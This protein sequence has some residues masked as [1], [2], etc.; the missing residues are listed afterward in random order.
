M[1][2]PSTRRSPKEPTKEEIAAHNLTHTPYRSW[3]PECV[4]ARGRANPHF[5]QDKEEKGVPGIHIDYLFMRDK[6]GADLI[7]VITIKDDDTKSVRAHVVPRKG[8]IDW[9]ADEVI[10][11]ISKLGHSAEVIIKSDQEPALIDLRKTIVQRRGKSAKT[12]EENAKNKDS[13]SNGVIERAIQGV[14]GMVRTMKFALEKR[15][16][17]TF[18]SSHPVMAWIIEH[19]AE[20]LNRYQVGEDGRTAYELTQGQDV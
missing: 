1:V 16:N 17:T 6:P 2:W 9:V 11:D 15:L 8:D 10:K 12:L 20:T 4:R 13:Q 5:K 7:P 3:C 18:E 19:A 14:E